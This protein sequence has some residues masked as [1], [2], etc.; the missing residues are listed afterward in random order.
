[1]IDARER[2]GHNRRLA[3]EAAVSE[4]RM[5]GVVA[6]VPRRHRRDPPCTLSTHHCTGAF[7]YYRAETVVLLAS[8]RSTARWL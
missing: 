8:P 1:M 3:L 4:H 2:Q 5:N 7:R 6:G